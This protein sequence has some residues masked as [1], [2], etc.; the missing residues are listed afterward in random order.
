[1]KEE[2]KSED[3]S[4]VTI[5]SEEED[6]KEPVDLTTCFYYS[7][8]DVGLTEWYKVWENY[9]LLR[10]GVYHELGISLLFLRHLFLG[11]SRE[12][13][14]VNCHNYR[15]QARIACLPGILEISHA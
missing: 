12:H 9:D 14:P 4:Y 13:D 8:F 5:S 1:M 10:K 3:G 11:N 2:E 15:L 7:N 6:E